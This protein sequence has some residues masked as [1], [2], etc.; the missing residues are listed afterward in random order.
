MISKII[1][2]PFKLTNKYFF[3]SY[4]LSNSEIEQFHKN[5]YIVK[6]KNIFSNT[7]I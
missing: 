7:I 4:L 5:G 2:K 1:S 6:T 3:S